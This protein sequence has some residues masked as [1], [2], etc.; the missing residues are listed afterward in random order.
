MRVRYDQYRAATM[1]ESLPIVLP[2]VSVDHHTATQFPAPSV[3]IG[4]TLGQGVVLAKEVASLSLRTHG[5]RTPSASHPKL[6]SLGLH[7]IGL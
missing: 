5:R 6:D 7:L 2:S 3:L 4:R 1:S